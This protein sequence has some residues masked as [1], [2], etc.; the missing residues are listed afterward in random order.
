VVVALAVA[1]AAFARYNHGRMRASLDEAENHIRLWIV[2]EYARANLPGVQDMDQKDISWK[3]REARLDRLVRQTRVEITS[4]EMRG[5]LIGGPVFRVEYTVDGKTPPDGESVR[6]YT[7]EYS[8]L[9]G[10]VD[11]PYRTWPIFWR[12]APFH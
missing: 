12:L 9:L 1:W 11:L 6:Y 7:M 5:A 3:E 10:W 8:P 4:L 2:S